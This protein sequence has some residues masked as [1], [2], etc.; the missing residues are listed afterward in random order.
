MVLGH[1]DFSL[2]FLRKGIF[3]S[4]ENHMESQVCMD[5]ITP[6]IFSFKKLTLTD[7]AES[8]QRIMVLWV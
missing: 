5:A 6:V 8:L 1:L 4:L 2:Y 7:D 3:Q